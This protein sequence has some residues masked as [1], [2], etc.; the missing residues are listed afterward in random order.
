MTRLTRLLP[1]LLAGFALPAQAQVTLNLDS[2]SS[3]EAAGLSMSAPPT[4]SMSVEAPSAES[5]S[6]EPSQ[7]TQPP[8]LSSSSD[9]EVDEQPSDDMPSEAPSG[10][11]VASKDALSDFFAA[12]NLAAGGVVDGARQLEDAGW[13]ANEDTDAGPFNTIYSGY[14]SFDGY[15]E[16]DIWG[17]LQVFPTQRLGYCRVDF[18]DPDGLINFG[19]MAG[20]GDLAGSTEDRGNGN[21]FGSWQSADK[22]ILVIADRVD[23][24][25]EI[26]F[27]FLLGDAPKS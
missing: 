19:D 4:I 16:V 21:V 6:A 10:P 8:N 15:G 3:G 13:L 17:A 25:V 24:T 27:N 23:G 5:S 22:H 18:S 1:V 26:E 14:R 7:M 2:S 20:I 12:C 11:P 9:E